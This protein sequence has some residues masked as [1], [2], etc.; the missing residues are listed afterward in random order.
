[1]LLILAALASAVLHTDDEKGFVAWMRETNQFFIGEEYWLRFGVWMTN[2]RI[3]RE[4]KGSFE[5]G[6]NWLSALT[7]TEYKALCGVR[8]NAEFPSV[9]PSPVN[10]AT[11]WDWRSKG[12]VN[13]VKWQGRCGSCWAFS[14]IQGAETANALAHG[15]LL[16]LSEKYLV[17]CC[18]DECLGCNGGY[19]ANAYEWVIKAH[20]G[21]WMLEDDYPYFPKDGPCKWNESLAVGS[22]I[23][24]EYVAKGNEDDLATK[25][26]QYGTAAVAIDSS[27]HAWHH[28][29]SGIFDDP[30]CNPNNLDHAVG[31]IGWGVLKGQKFWIVKN[32]WGVG[33]GNKG[34]INMIWKNNQCGIANMAMV[35]VA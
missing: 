15:K 4:W 17:D 7:P 30:T 1:M 24:V 22:L 23:R 33:F 27:R 28:Y 16:N 25:I 20:K 21:R 11:E 8:P 2:A 6:L 31:C 12:V 32:S 9:R 14:T 34:Y 3:V 29:K 18:H 26:Q 5:I 19:M 35:P 10:Y 13:G